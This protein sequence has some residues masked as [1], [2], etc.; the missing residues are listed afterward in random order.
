MWFFAV[1]LPTKRMMSDT[2][3]AMF[4]YYFF[5]SLYIPSTLISGISVL[6]LSL[7]LKYISK[8]LEIIAKYQIFKLTTGHDATL[9][10]L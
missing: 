7:L 2:S 3:S 1:N 6:G 8:I 9:E 5:G 10:L 4:V